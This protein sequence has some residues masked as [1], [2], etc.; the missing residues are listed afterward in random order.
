MTDDAGTKQN[1]R[2]FSKLTQF[3]QNKIT[4]KNV[5]YY[6]CPSRKDSR[7][8]Y[9]SYIFMLIT[10]FIIFMIAF[11]LK[12]SVTINYVRWYNDSCTID[13][14]TTSPIMECDRSLRLYC[15]TT[16]ERCACLVNMHWNC[17][18]CDCAQGMYY[19]GITC[20]ERLGFGQSCDSQSDICME[21]LTCSKSTNSC[22]CPSSS[23]YNQTGCNTRIGFNGI[24]P[25]TLSSQCVSGLICSSNVCLCLASQTWNGDGCQN[26]STNGEYCVANLQ[27][28]SSAL[29][30]CNTTL[31]RCTCG[32]SSYWDGTICR[33]RLNNGSLCN[34]TQQCYS[35]LICINGYCQ[36]PYI[37]TQYWSSQTST[38]ELC[39]GT[40]LF[41]FDGICY[42][43]PV[44]TN[45]TRATYSVLSSSNR[46]ST[47]QYDY[48]LNYV[49]SQH[50]RVFNWTLIFLATINPVANYFQWAPDNTLI[51]PSYFCNETVRLNY[52]GYVISFKLE[53]NTPCLRA[54]PNTTVGQLA[55]QLNAYT[56]HTK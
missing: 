19:N 30:T 15:S 48:Q 54:L 38:C 18:F 49:F 2:L 31:S 33:Q 22:D 50:V 55:N 40:D 51:K 27:C 23:Y 12:P 36:C 29:L 1:S 25:C 42:H 44:A 53:T 5:R 26:L 46:L 14:I 13:S 43:I 7:I 37:Y 56:Y 32:V 35:S 4:W 39:Y 6:C 34:N 3:R 16:A 10:L 52:T 24:Q 45:S 17:S 28:D 9:Y 20:Q 11:L 8:F 41:L 21:Y 47:I